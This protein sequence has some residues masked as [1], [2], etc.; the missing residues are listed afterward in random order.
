[1]EKHLCQ[2]LY[3]TPPVAVFEENNLAHRKTQ[4]LGSPPKM[5]SKNLLLLITLREILLL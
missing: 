1:M 4:V 5:L 3:R 2:S